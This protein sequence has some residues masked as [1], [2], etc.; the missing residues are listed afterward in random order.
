MINMKIWLDDIRPAPDGYEWVLSVNAAKSLITKCMINKWTIEVIDMDHDLGD[1]APSGG[2][3]Y[4]L[5]IWLIENDFYPPIAL[6]TQNVV[7]RMNMQALINRY[8]WD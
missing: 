8:W 2:D 1:Y 6:H 3:G 4:K 5:L 7:G